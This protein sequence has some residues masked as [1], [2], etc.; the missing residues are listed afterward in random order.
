M[1]IDLTNTSRKKQNWML[2]V[3]KI[4][5]ARNR[6]SNC[7]CLWKIMRNLENSCNRIHTH[8]QPLPTKKVNLTPRES[9]QTNYT[10]RRQTRNNNILLELQ[11][12]SKDVHQSHKNARP[13]VASWMCGYYYL[14]SFLFSPF[15]AVSKLSL[16]HF[17]L[18]LA[19]WIFISPQFPNFYIYFHFVFIFIFF[20]SIFI[21]QN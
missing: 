11:N 8:T 1:R 19:Y 15:S 16:I 13:L 12:I 20:F 9:N 5:T 17:N 3:F 4:S 21:F 6:K 7:W 10:I 14:Y 18:D 2:V